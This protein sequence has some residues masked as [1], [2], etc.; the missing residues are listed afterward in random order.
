MHK[1]DRLSDEDLYTGYTHSEV[2]GDKIN[3]FYENGDLSIDEID[4][5]IDFYPNEFI[6]LNTP[7][8]GSKQSAL[9]IVE[10]DRLVKLRNEKR[11]ASGIKP[12]NREQTMA[13]ELLLRDE[14][15]LITMAGKAGTGKTL[16]AVA[17]GLEK[18][19]HEK[20]YTRILVARPVVPMGKDIGFLPGTK[21]D[22][23]QPWM[24]PILII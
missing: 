1:A 24:Q 17:A 4:S 7:G 2:S 19:L 14:V 22:K 9:G 3:K 12:L 21:E 15:E 11:T 6:N 16:L 20:K 13:I 10:Q 23:L 8:E 18:V 5:E